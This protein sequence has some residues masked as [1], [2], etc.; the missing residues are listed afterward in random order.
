MATIDGKI[1]VPSIYDEP[2]KFPGSK[3]WNSVINDNPEVV[4]KIGGRLYPLR[5]RLVTD[6]AEFDLA[7]EALAGKY[8]FWRGVKDEAD[9]RPP[10]VLISM[11]DP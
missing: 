7:L 11:D 3:Y 4:M 2:A 9:E 6:V 10:F 8:S 5:A 1:Y